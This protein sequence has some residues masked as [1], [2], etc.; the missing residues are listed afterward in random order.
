[1]KHGFTELNDKLKCVVRLKVLSAE[2][3]KKNKLQRHLETNHPNCINKPV[4]FF[5]RKL[6]SIQ[7]ERSIMTLFTAENKLTVY[8][9][10]V[11]SYKIV[12]QKKADTIGEDL[13]MPVIKEVVKI[14]IGEKECKKLD[15]VSLSN[16]TVKKRNA[17]MSNDV[18]QQIVHQVKKSPLYSIQLDESTDIAGLPQLSVFI[19]YIN[20][21]TTSEVS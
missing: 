17:N 11:A 18:I 6:K 9:L 21:A 16:N 4:E 15:T 1:M 2:S 13:L 5:E 3:M 10:Y 8:S 20:N 14:M 7:G 12:K 19:H